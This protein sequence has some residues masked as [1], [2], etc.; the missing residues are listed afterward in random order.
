M[1]G[2]FVQ[3][4]DA[5]ADGNPFTSEGLFVSDGSGPAVDVAEGD[6]VRITCTVGESFGM[7][8]ISAESVEVIS[9][10]MELA[11]TPV[12]VNLPTSTYMLDDDGNPVADL[13]SY[14]GMAVRIEQDLTVTEMFNLDRYGEIR[15]SEGGQLEQFTQNYDPDAV[16]YAQHLQ[17]IAKR[18]I[19]IDDG[20][21]T[22]N[23]DTLFIPHGDD[24][25]LTAADQF[26][27]GDTLGNVTGV[28]NYDFDEFRLQRPSADYHNTNSRPEA[29]EDVG[30]S[31]KVASF[32]VL[33]YFTTLDDG[34]SYS[35]NPL[36]DA[37]LEPGGAD[38]LTAFGVTPATAEFDR[39]TEKLVNALTDI[40]ADIFGL[41]ELENSNTDSA[42]NTIVTELNTQVG[43]GA[44][45]YVS[46][47]G[48]VGT[49]GITVGFICKTAT[50]APVG[51]LAILDDASFT[52]P[53]DT[54]QQ[55]NRPALAQT[56][57]EIETGAVLTPV[58][59]HFKSKGDSGL[60][61][62]DDGIPDDPSNPDSDQFD[63]QGYW[64]DTRTDAA[65]AL[66]D[67]LSDDP[68]GS[69]DADFLILGDLN[70]YAQEDPVKA[71][72]TAG[73]TDLARQSLGDDAYSY[74]FDGQ[75]GRLD[76]AFASASLASQVTGV[77]EW[78]IN[79]DEA[80]AID[81]NLDFG[82]ADDVFDGDSA[83]RNSDHDPVIVG[84]NL[85][86]EVVEPMLAV[87]SLAYDNGCF[88]PELDYSENGVIIA[89]VRQYPGLQVRDP[90][91]QIPLS[92]FAL[93]SDDAFS[94]SGKLF[95]YDLEDRTRVLLNKGIAVRDGDDGLSGSDTK[96]IDD[97]ETLVIE[98]EDDAAFDFATAGTISLG[99]IK[100]L[101]PSVVAEAV[102]E[103]ESVGVFGLS[104]GAI[105][106]DPDGDQGFDRV[107]I[108]A[109]GRTQFTFLGV[110]LLDLFH[111]D[112][113]LVA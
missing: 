21:T 60:D 34:I 96:R 69:G 111:S 6:L 93:D 52:D 80:D 35:D 56:F 40:D 3:E 58:I 102:L 11:V 50:V 77:T 110:E 107:E 79:A 18:S 48:L 59:N 66:A 33:N 97:D 103:G 82:R 53:N 44:Y 89:E 108:S 88:F 1:N 46:T 95:R 61:A 26:R 67:W 75:T 98:I 41:V 74:V 73:Y 8:Q 112:D 7:T 15:V 92:I 22:Q 101:N 87:A 24:E 68:T 84:L 38:D 100:G 47:G 28:L 57:E 45:A 63:G 64:N 9:A 90:H 85:R 4:A 17:D 20:L 16:G 55:R 14:E 94:R 2:F 42:L 36:T 25:T 104:N 70:A 30:G 65:K 81:Y 113:A 109:E 32:N 78:H 29:P 27:M 105:A 54:G 12:T 23:P 91:D 39:Q 72:E 49:D 62:V 5:D 10:H 13:E 51:D 19:V 86:P 31:L 76:Y 71:L 106:I 99:K 43:A 37:G 83:A